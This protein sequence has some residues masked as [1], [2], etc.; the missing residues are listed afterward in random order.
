MG[1]RRA[2]KCLPR[3]RNRFQVIDDSRTA[4]DKE[5]QGFVSVSE[6]VHE[7]PGVRYQVE[8]MAMRKKNADARSDLQFTSL[9]GPRIPSGRAFRIDFLT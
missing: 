2:V 1:L 5:G 4:L 9:A 6:P 7:V 8:T 3:R